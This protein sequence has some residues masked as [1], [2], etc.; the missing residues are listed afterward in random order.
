MSKLDGLRSTPTTDGEPRL[1]GSETFGLALLGRYLPQG[2]IAKLRAGDVGAVIVQVPNPRFLS[3]VHDGLCAMTPEETDVT[4]AGGPGWHDTIAMESLAKGHGSVYVCSDIARVPAAFRAFAGP[5]FTIG[6][7]D[8]AMVGEVLRSFTGTS[9][10][11]PKSARLHVD[12]SAICH[13]LVRGMAA[14]TILRAILSLTDPMA[15]DGELQPR[16]ED[17]V[18]YGAARGWALRLKSDLA[19]WQRG[20]IDADEI[21][22]SILLHSPPGYGKT[23][24][25]KILARSIG[26]PLHSIT[27]GKLF[28]GEGYLGD[29]LKALRKAFND[30]AS[31]VPSVLLIDELDAFPDRRARDVNSHFMGAMV[32]ELLTLLDGASKKAPGMI[33]VGATNLLD[34]IDPALR[35]PGRLSTTVELPLPGRAGVARILRQHLQGELMGDDIGEVVDAA[36]GSTPA[37]LMHMVRVAR[38]MARSHRRPMEI[39]DLKAQ[40]LADQDPPPAHHH[41]RRLAVHEAGHAVAIS[42]L[43]P[44][45]TIHEVSIR[46]GRGTHG[47]VLARTG[48]ANMTFADLIA[49]VMVVL[50]GRAAEEALLGPQD[51]GLGAGGDEG[52]DLWHAT[53]L[54]A[55]LRGNLGAGSLVW[56]GGDDEIVDVVASDPAFRSLVEADL[57]RYYQGTV[58][59]MA[60]HADALGAIADALLS[61]GTV[62]GRELDALIETRSGAGGACAA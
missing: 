4:V 17:C 23:T 8:A 51:L 15:T 11:V 58:Q 53:T 18:E 55:R 56:R 52:S 19:A 39:G 40:A 43:K 46:G 12:P 9:T 25:A 26:A 31:S 24:F 54:S 57:K 36:E 21:D 14:K 32:A 45:D 6:A 20:E 61:K 29:V 13:C 48:A 42:I 33:V 59:L 30:A 10:R 41:L 7:H 44:Q 2:I 47:H 38:S 27:M 22:G 49:E 37:E 34:R 5:H 50:A 3:I 35:R 16:M 60:S 28:A 62:S 1:T